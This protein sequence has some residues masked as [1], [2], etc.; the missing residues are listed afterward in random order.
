MK[1]KNKKKK[2]FFKFVFKII[3]ILMFCFIITFFTLV[4]LK[5]KTINY[6][7]VDQAKLQI[8]NNLLYELEETEL[9]NVSAKEIKD[10]RNI[11]LIGN[12]AREKVNIGARA[13]TIMVLSINP[14]KKSIK[15]I[16]LPR[17]TYVNIPGRGMDKLNHA[18]AYGKEKLLINTINSNFNL[19]IEDYITINF[20][21][22]IELINEVG[23]VK[24][25][26]TE[27][28][29][30]YINERSHESYDLTNRAYK[31]IDNAG[32]VLLDGE[33][34]LT[35][36]RNRTIGNDFIRQERQRTIIQEVIKEFKNL[37]LGETIGVVKKCLKHV[38]TNI[39]IFEYMKVIPSVV[40]H[41]EEYSNNIISTQI[42]SVRYSS[43]KKIRGIYYFVPDKD[44]AI[45]DFADYIYNK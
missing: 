18:Y 14:A 39:N 23:G 43:G 12:D 20:R 11:M 2:N 37:D 27:S 34:T 7:F 17:D 9:E 36:A 42:P 4:W 30:K 6:E 31:N 21:G 1:K 25:N 35:H 44:K 19:K 40:A 26:I 29:R 5:M 10:I 33:Q 13:D 22:L 38:S 32:Y 16:S 24:L 3:I 8:N 45:N 28:E 41:K 15:L